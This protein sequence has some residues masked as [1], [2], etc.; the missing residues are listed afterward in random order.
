MLSSLKLNTLNRW[1]FLGVTLLAFASLSYNARAVTLAV[2]GVYDE[3]VNQ[4][5]S[6]DAQAPGNVMSSSAFS[7][8]VGSAF[9]SGRG[10]VIHFDTAGNTNAVIYNESL[11]VNFGSGKHLFITSSQPYNFR[12]FGSIFSLSGNGAADG[13]KGLAPADTVSTSATEMTFNFTNI[14]GGL[15]GERITTAGFTLLSRNGFSQDVSVDWFVS[16]FA[17]PY[18]TQLDNIDAGAGVD[19]TFFSFTAPVN[20]Y[21]FGFRIVYGGATGSND[22]RLGI[23]DLGFITSI[24]P[25]PARA[26][27]FCMALVGG[28]MIRRRS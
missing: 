7:T 24:V 12:H 5:N 11:D 20:S 25:E 19:D 4:T 26:L 15:P 16:G 18:I 27:F 28:V 6:V 13:S 21:I 8:A 10:G 1:F 9:T 3:N 22:R 17:N 14:T 23:D 2:S